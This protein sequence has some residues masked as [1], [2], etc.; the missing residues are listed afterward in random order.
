MIQLLEINLPG[1]APQVLLQLFLIDR[2]DSHDLM[3]ETHVFPFPT[4]PLSHTL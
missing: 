1:Q 3:F 4:N 2:S